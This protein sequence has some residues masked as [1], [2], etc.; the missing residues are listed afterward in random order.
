MET[1]LG[2]QQAG[3]GDTRLTCV[4]TDHSV[5]LG[6]VGQEVIEK[7]PGTSIEFV[8]SLD[9]LVSGHFAFLSGNPRP[10]RAGRLHRGCGTH[11]PFQCRL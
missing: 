9:I 4:L 8:A 6:S 1:A 2:C 11:V 3:E 5:G 7:R 10:M